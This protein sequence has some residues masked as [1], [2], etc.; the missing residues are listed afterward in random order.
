MEKLRHKE[1]KQFAQSQAARIWSRFLIQ[2]IWN[3]HPSSPFLF[4]HLSASREGSKCCLGSSPCLAWKGN[5]TH[6]LASETNKGE[7]ASVSFQN[8]CA[9]STDSQR[10]LTV[11]F[12]NWILKSISYTR[13]KSRNIQDEYTKMESTAVPNGSVSCSKV[14][15]PSPRQGSSWPRILSEI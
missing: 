3:H 8:S 9:L 6:L 13:L 1:I 14:P 4:L 10:H 5:L 12:T 15:S 2:I 11:N 7:A